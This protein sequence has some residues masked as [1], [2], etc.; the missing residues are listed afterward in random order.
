MALVGFQNIGNT[1]YLNSGLHMLLQN[2]DLC[3]LIIKYENYNDTL[4][5]IASFI[6]EYWSGSKSIMN[7][8]IIKKIAEQ[9]KNIFIGSRQH[10]SPE[11]VLTLLDIIDTAI[12]KID[13]NGLDSIYGIDMEDIVKCKYIPCLKYTTTNIKT[14]VLMLDLH[15][16]LDDSYRDF[17]QSIRLENDNKY[18]CENCQQKRIASKRTQII[19]WS[20]NLIIWLKRFKQQTNTRWTKNNDPLQVPLQWRHGFKLN[21]AIIHSGGINGGHYIYVGLVNNEWYIFNDS[22]V[23]KI[24]NGAQLE[25]YLNSAYMLYYKK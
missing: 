17:K 16:T 23:S 4:K 25:N 3:R 5:I 18:Y 8:S 11:F 7:P 13:K 22:S 2:Q 14:I 19:N 1:C 24:N 12:K 10:D 21:G 6:N 20:N 15:N 9:N